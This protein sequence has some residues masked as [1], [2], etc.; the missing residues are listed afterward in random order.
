MSKTKNEDVDISVIIPAF[1]E[2]ESI[3]HLYKHLKK[4]LEEISKDKYE[5]IFID[6]G[7]NDQTLKAMTDIHET[8]KKVSVYSHRKNFGKAQAMATGFT[9]AKG[10]YIFTLDADDLVRES[11]R[12]ANVAL[13]GF[14]IAQR[15]LPLPAAALRA[16]VEAISPEPFCAL[17]LEAFGRGMD[18]V[19]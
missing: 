1:N 18:A 10:K 17:N 7:S 15:A 5:I 4:V 3:P 8:D 14:A 16:T 12:V 11:P 9:H 6:D 2:A 19:Q 13:V